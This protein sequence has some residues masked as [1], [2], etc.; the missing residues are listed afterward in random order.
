[1][2][3]GG[4]ASGVGK[5]TVT[6]AL[7]ACMRRRGLTVQAFKGGPDFLDTTHHSRIAGRPARNLDTWM[8]GPE[9]N[10]E[11]LRSATRG[12]DA[13]I[14]EGMM[15]LF[16]GK[17]GGTEAGSSAEIAKLLRLPV[18]LVLDCAKSARSVAAVV[19]GFERFDP[20]LPLAGVILNR[21]AGERH[22]AMLREA[23]TGACRTPV[24]GWLPR[25]LSIAIPE[26]H[27][28]LHGAMQISSVDEVEAL[29]TQLDTLGRLAEEHLAVDQILALQCGLDLNEGEPTVP[30]AWEGST[31]R[32]GVARDAAFSFY[33]EDNLDLLREQGA[34]I[35]PFSPVEDG[36]LPAD[37]DALYLGGGYPELQ[38]ERL[39][40][41]STMREQVRAFAARGGVV[42]AECGG[43]IY[44]AES[45]AT[46]DGAVHA[47]VGALPL[48]M[49]MTPR[50]VDFGY[51][52][53]ELTQDCLLGPRGTEMRGHSFHTSR[54][55]A[56]SED[57]I[58]TSYRVRFSLSGKEQR[59]GFARDRVL[60]SYAHLH[61]RA[62]PT[63][64]PH[65]MQQIRAAREARQKERARA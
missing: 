54:I 1:M 49:E 32:I 38:A 65:L 10:R 41:N 16:D 21:V 40:A 50:L 6:L 20:E 62:N 61:F 14:A 39:A 25:E 45:L 58:E 28:G 56:G 47:M 60:A 30:R 17:G 9:A 55:V 24:L 15:G 63:V 13:M 46:L 59:E 7:I 27:L 43:M 23:I 18:V 22:Y 64:V 29:E 35:V 31:L 53:V 44:L 36:A 51:V 48:A 4:T 2:L 42:Y 5:T 33:Y 26:R 52:E 11:V 57:G 12:A 8:L 19:L 34:E 3:V 37:L